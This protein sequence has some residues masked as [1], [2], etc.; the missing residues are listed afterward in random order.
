MGKEYALGPTSELPPGTVV[1]AGPYAVGNGDGQYFAVSRRCRHLGADLAKGSIDA[2]GCLVC[3]WHQS[4]Y[5]VHTGLMVRGPQ[6]MFA[7]VPG[8]GS[9]FKALTRI[10]PLRRGEVTERAG[11]LYVR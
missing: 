9:A 4:T 6:G 10:V 11:D 3:P 2:E 1:G 8:L 7:K 5:D